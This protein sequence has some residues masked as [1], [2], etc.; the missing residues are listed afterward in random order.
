MIKIY[1]KEYLDLEDINNFKE[2][3]IYKLRR[4]VKKLRKDAKELWDYANCEG[5]VRVSEECEKKADGL[6]ELIK[7]YNSIEKLEAKIHSK[8]RIDKK[9]F[10]KV[11][12]TYPSR[13]S[14]VSETYDRKY[15]I[16]YI[17]ME[18][19]KCSLNKKEKFIYVPFKAKKVVL[20]EIK[21]IV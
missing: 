12:L 2:K 9:E 5:M 19:T 4:E 7:N 18:W 20:K 16:Y 3:T 10:W 11:S 14:I 8:I 21:S 17:Q 15:N 6:E 13:F 1:K